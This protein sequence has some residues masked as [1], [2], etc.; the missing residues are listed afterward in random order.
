ML[1]GQAGGTLG[2][3]Q[4]K[5]SHDAGAGIGSLAGHIGS[6]TGNG[7]GSAAHL[8]GIGSGL[9]VGSGNDV[10]GSIDLVLIQ[11]RDSGVGLQGADGA[12]VDRD[13]E[14]G[15]GRAV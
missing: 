1:L 11:H 8:S 10:I 6:A 9:G 4:L 5:G 2:A 12:A 14:I 15:I 13:L 7:I 3:Q